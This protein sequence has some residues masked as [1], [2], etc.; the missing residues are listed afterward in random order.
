MDKLCSRMQQDQDFIWCRPCLVNEIDDKLIVYAGNQRVRAAKKLKWK[1]IP[2]IIEKNLSEE[3]IKERTISDNTHFGAW[4]MDV[5]ANVY[6][7]DMLID[8]G[9][10]DKDFNFLS[11]IDDKTEEGSKLECEKCE[12]CGQKLKKKKI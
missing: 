2:C 9:F 12:S 7:L 4:D 5:L 6:D 3:M 10:S 1:D 8:C 11:D